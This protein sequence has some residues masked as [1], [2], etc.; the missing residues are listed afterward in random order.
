MI[1]IHHLDLPLWRPHLDCLL[2]LLDATEAARA[3][4][5]RFAA[6]RERHIICQGALRLILASATGC[7]P[8]VLEILRGPHG[9]PHLAAHHDPA[10]HFNLS[11]AGQ[12]ALI[13][14]AT[15]PVGVDIEPLREI[16]GSQEIARAQFTK[17]EFSQLITSETHSHDFLRIWT[18]KEALLKAMGDGLSRS[19]A[20]I[21]VGLELERPTGLRQWRLI[22]VDI[23]GHAAC[24]CVQGEN[25]TLSIIDAVPEDFLPG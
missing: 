17:H 21:E 13:A 25:S 4:R 8:H 11:H 22:N 6:D 10:P 12:K 3:G 5:F 7:P 18:R 15:S 2:P 23:S 14:L 24:V 16:E 19:L 20:S 9:K 1:Q